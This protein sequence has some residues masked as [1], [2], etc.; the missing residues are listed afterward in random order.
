MLGDCEKN[1][2]DA[3]V[4][5]LLLSV[6]ADRVKSSPEILEVHD[7]MLSLEIFS[8]G[9]VKDPSCGLSSLIEK[10]DAQVRDA[11]DQSNLIEITDAAINQIDDPMLIP[12]MVTAMLSVARSDGEYHHSIN[13]FITRAAKIWGLPTVPYN[14]NQ[15]REIITLLQELKLEN[16]E[17]P[18]TWFI[19]GLV[20]PW[21]GLIQEVATHYE[22]VKESPIELNRSEIEEVRKEFKAL[23]RLIRRNPDTPLKISCKCSEL[24]KTAVGL[25][26]LG[27]ASVG[28]DL[29]KTTRGIKRSKRERRNFVECLN[30]AASYLNDPRGPS[31]DIALLDFATDLVE[32]FNNATGRKIGRGFKYE[33]PSHPGPLERYLMATIKPVRSHTTIDSVRGLIRKLQNR[34]R[35]LSAV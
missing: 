7:R 3:V 28:V 4:Q 32:V 10:Y 33:D 9:E 13:D 24:S 26:N 21:A 6:Y 31:E 30:R 35:V 11:I 19:D 12:L 18:E 23:K 29:E 8:G 22:S 15:L 14:D 16:H 17:P 27:A 34:N 20:Q 2:V 25:L 5:L 1:S